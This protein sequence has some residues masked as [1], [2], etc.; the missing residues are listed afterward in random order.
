ML[1]LASISLH[2]NMILKT[3][4]IEAGFLLRLKTSVLI[5]I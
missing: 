2:D 1:T 5:L 4:L 3:R